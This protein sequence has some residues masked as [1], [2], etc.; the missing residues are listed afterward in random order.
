M[1][2]KKS[3]TDVD[4]SGKHPLVR[5][6]FNVPIEGGEITDETRI[7]AALPTINALLDAGCAVT[8][9]SHLGRPK[10]KVVPEE[11]LA[12]VAE[13]LGRILN[14]EVTMAPDCVGEEV[15]RMRADLQ[16]GQVLMLENT[17]FHAG[18]EKNDRDF[19]EQLAGDA[20]LFIDDAFGSMHRAH[21]STV[22]VTEFIGECVSGLLVRE[23]LDQ[24][25]RCREASGD[26]FIVILGGA[27]VE[28]KIDAIRQLL[29]RV[30]KLLVGGAMAWSF[31]KVQGMEIGESLSKPESVEAAGAILSEL[32]EYRD[33][34]MLPLDVHMKQVEPDTGEM[35]FADADAIEPGWDALD[36]GPKTR[37][38]YRRIITKE[39]EV[40]FWNG[41]MGLFEV[42]PFDEGTR[43]VA[44]ALADTEAF[45]V[46]GGGDSAAAITQMGFEDKLSHVSTGGGASIEYVQGDELPGV[47]ALDEA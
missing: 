28:D 21:A 33:R 35:K 25:T 29:P 38:E 27:K 32:S 37:E 12:P 4:L 18:E 26:G 11:S 36:I 44:Q 20:D 1:A 43:A 14:A 5:V 3:I 47:E 34:L 6:D 24:L 31:L 45:T 19:A 23:E 42:S 46:V 9:C 16:P 8:L 17:R 13:R 39:A 30:E 10:G 40:V 7:K 2:R 41:P 22:G 15:A